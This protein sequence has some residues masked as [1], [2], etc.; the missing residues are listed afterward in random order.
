MVVAK[1]DGNR[2]QIHT[3]DINFFIPVGSNVQLQASTAILRSSSDRSLFD[4]K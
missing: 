4:L 3:K 2:N 1:S